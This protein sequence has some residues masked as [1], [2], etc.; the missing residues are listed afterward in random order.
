MNDAFGSAPAASRHRTTSRIPDARSGSPRSSREKQAY[1]IGCH[2]FGPVGSFSRG[3]ASRE[4]ARDLVASP[5][6]HAQ[7]EIVA[8]ERRDRRRAVPAR[9]AGPSTS[10]SRSARRRARRRRAS[11]PRRGTSAVARSRTR[12][13]ALPPAARARSTG[14]PQPCDGAWPRRAGGEG[15][16]DVGGNAAR[17]CELLPVLGGSARRAESHVRHR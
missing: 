2:P 8:G 12:I 3:R 6:A 1:R 16:D 15:Q 7:R 9:A 4:P 10:P 14:T 13:R 17:T 11:R 5:V